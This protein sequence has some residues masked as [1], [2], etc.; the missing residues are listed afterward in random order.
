[1]SDSELICLLLTP[2]YCLIAC[3]LPHRL[4]DQLLFDFGGGNTKTGTPKVYKAISFLTRVCVKVVAMLQYMSV[5]PYIFLHTFLHASVCDTNRE[6]THYYHADFFN[7]TFV[8]AIRG[9]HCPGEVHEFL[10][11]AELRAVA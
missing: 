3:F 10:Y 2:Y 8:R 4:P 9:N 5:C 6:M 1:M 7:F 11:N